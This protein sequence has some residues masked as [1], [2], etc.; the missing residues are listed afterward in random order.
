MYIKFRPTFLDLQMV[1]HLVDEI[2]DQ[3]LSEYHCYY[4]NITA[5]PQ[6]KETKNMIIMRM[7]AFT[8]SS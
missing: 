2:I 5:V 3:T 7:F 1:L 4:S 8:F 6:K